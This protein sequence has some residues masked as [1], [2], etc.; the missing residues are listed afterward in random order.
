MSRTDAAT[1]SSI[2]LVDDDFLVRRAVRRRLEAEGFAVTAAATG[3]DASRLAACT[4]PFEVGV[5]DLDLP[6]AHGVE[7]AR[8]LLSRGQVRRAVFFSATTDPRERAAATAHGRFV[9]KLAPVTELVDAIHHTL[10]TER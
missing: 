7:L 10:G 5:F 9:P 1:V 8:A 6:D 2:L 4:D 3:D